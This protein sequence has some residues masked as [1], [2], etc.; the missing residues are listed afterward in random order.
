M[1]KLGLT[2]LCFIPLIAGAVPDR[3]VYPSS[4]TTDAKVDENTDIGGFSA[5]PIDQG[6][7]QV[8]Q[9]QEDESELKDKNEEF[10]EGPYDKKGNY[11]YIPE[12][13]P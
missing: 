11:R 1:K 10:I 2:L 9:E 7:G 6:T 3:G 5:S 8:P 13:R 12:I 4:G